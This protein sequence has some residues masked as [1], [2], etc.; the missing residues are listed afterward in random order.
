[1]DLGDPDALRSLNELFR[2]A[3]VAEQKQEHAAPVK[4]A[5]TTVVSGAKASDGKDIW[6]EDEIPSEEALHDPHDTRPCPRYEIR[7]KQRVGAEDVFLGMSEKTPGSS[8]CTHLVV[9][10]H[11]P[12]AALADLDLKVTKRR[13]KA[14]SP[15][16][17][18]STYLPL[19][20]EDDKG[21]A[22]WDK[23]KHV[24]TVTLP[25]SEDER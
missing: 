4:T 22:Q 13:I 14:E 5:P 6:E 8:D 23:A 19:P 9:K 16:L 1:M 25:I 24:L 11:F 7:Y 3:E 15:R 12:G 2:Q 21:V 10:V 20:V 17:L 18:L